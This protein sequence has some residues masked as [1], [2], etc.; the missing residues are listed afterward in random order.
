MPG[1]QGGTYSSCG[2]PRKRSRVRDA[3]EARIDGARI[4]RIARAL[5]T[6]YLWELGN[7]NYV[8]IGEAPPVNGRKSRERSFSRGKLIH[9]HADRH[10]SSE[11]QTHEENHCNNAPHNAIYTH[12]RPSER[13]TFQ[14]AS[15]LE[16]GLSD[17]PYFETFVKLLDCS[18]RVLQHANKHVKL[19]WLHIRFIRTR[20]TVRL[21][22]FFKVVWS[23]A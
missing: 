18:R 3:R 10:V 17:G 15:G 8:G 23:C 21:S 12:P 13:L 16:R 7:P 6:S 14:P 2:A 11:P 19:R 5:Q 20:N 4:K 22:V 9:K 1:E